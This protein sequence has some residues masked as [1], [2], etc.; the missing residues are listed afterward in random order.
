MPNRSSEE[1]QE[2]AEDIN[3]LAAQIIEEA[4]KENSE[5]DSI[6]EQLGEES[7]EKNKNL[8]AQTLERLGGFKGGKV[9]TAKLTPE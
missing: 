2:K 6:K 4:T 9:R 3:K 1:K 5:E 7:V 8:H